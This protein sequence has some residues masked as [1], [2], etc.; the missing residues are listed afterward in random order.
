[1][2]IAT[3]G[4][5]VSRALDFYKTE[6]KYFIIG[7]TEPWRDE[8][9]PTPP[10]LNDYRLNDVVAL[11]KVYNTFLVVPDENGTIEYRTQNWKK[12]S[13][14]FYTSIGSSG[15]TMNSKVI[16]VESIRGIVE[17]VRLRINNSYEGKVTSISGL[18]IT[19]DTPAPVEIPAGSLVEG[20][21]Y[22]E[23]AKYVYID[24]YLNYDE[25]PIVRY[26]QIGLCTGVTPNTGDTL[27]SA[28]Y[29]SSGSDEYS[30]LG[31]LEVLDNRVPS[32]RDIDQRE[33]LSLIIEF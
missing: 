5:H 28:K 15:V 27:R 4:G 32:T 16:P 12:V 13:E 22:V 17:G 21:A 7:G 1:M 23:A 11:K 18:N 30:S 3:N 19:L 26:R 29:S 6:G 2:A 31:V 33:L 25:F 20:G 14:P 10:S 24:A 9:T 8:S